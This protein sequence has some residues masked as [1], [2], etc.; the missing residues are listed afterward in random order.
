MKYYYAKI[1][2]FYKTNSMKNQISGIILGLQ[3]SRLE[4][5]KAAIIG[6]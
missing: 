2:S 3:K 6:K 1:I 4:K 5:Y